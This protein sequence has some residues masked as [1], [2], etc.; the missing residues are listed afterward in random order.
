MFL[1]NARFYNCLGNRIYS[2]FAVLRKIRRLAQEYEKYLLL[3]RVV[4]PRQK[5]FVSKHRTPLLLD[6]AKQAPEGWWDHWPS[7][8]WDEAQKLKSPISPVRMMK[9]AQEAGH[10]DLGMVQEICKDLRVGCDLG[11]RGEYLCPSTS[12]NAPSAYEYGDRV[13]DSIIDGIKSGIMM[14]PMTKE[15]IPFREKGIKVSGIMVKLKPNG[16]ARVILNMS[17]GYP[18]CV[19]E[20]MTNEERFEVSMSSSI[21]WLRSLHK[22]GR[23]CWL[24]KLDWA[25]E[26]FCSTPKYL[27]L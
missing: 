26:D 23:G 15:Q 5:V 1:A 2:S 8:A 12:T 24:T 7:L 10:P 27:E 19:N 4:Q 13:T 17:K 3:P 9:W 16:V 21:Q 6:Y 22:A 25:G 14:G 20:G 11:T 18:F